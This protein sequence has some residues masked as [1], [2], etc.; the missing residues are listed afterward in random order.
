MSLKRVNAALSDTPFEQRPALLRSV[1]GMSTFA[2]LDE[3]LSRAD[4]H[5]ERI[6]M[7]NSASSE[8]GPSRRPLTSFDM[9]PSGGNGVAATVSGDLLRTLEMG[10]SGGILRSALT[11]GHDEEDTRTMN[12]KIAS[13]GIVNGI[14]TN[15]I[16]DK[17]RKRRESESIPYPLELQESL[18]GI[19]SDEFQLGAWWNSTCG[20]SLL[21]SGISPLPTSVQIDS[22]PNRLIGGDNRKRRRKNRNATSMEVFGGVEALQKNISTIARLRKTHAKFG[23]LTSHIENNEPI[24]AALAVVSSDESETEDSTQKGEKEGGKRL[25]K[26]HKEMDMPAESMHDA[27]RNPFAKLSSEGATEVLESKTQILLAHAG[28]EGAQRAAA[29]V[30]TDVASEYIMNLGRTIRMYM[31]Q[32]AHEMS[33]EEIVLHSLFENG[34]MDVRNLESYTVDD[35][36]RYGGKMSELL[37]KLQ[38]SYRDTLNTTNLTMED[39]A[40]FA[41]NA[42]GNNDQIMSGTFAQGMGDDFFGFKEMGLDKELGIDMSR[43]IVPSKLFNKGAATAAGHARTLGRVGM[44]ANLGAIGG[45]RGGAGGASNE[46]FLFEPPPPYVPLTESAISAQIGLLQPFYRELIRNRGQWQ[47]KSRRHRRDASGEGGEDGE[48]QEEEEDEEDEGEEE[49]D[50]SNHRRNSKSI[51]FLPEEEMERQRYKVPPNGKMPK[52]AMKVKG[53]EQGNNASN[54]ERNR[55][56]TTIAPAST[57]GVVSSTTSTKTKSST[58]KKK[59]KDASS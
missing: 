20:S 14:S 57:A 2:T 41:E 48:G 12:G 3:S 36:L 16:S 9:E 15:G 59:K 17:Q 25:R 52:R 23:A 28:F 18:E 47:Q 51:L 34:G 5:F 35:V 30:I 7:A 40:Y 50:E 11:M 54:S 58:S 19:V 24:P 31:D 6:Y 26:R 39:E 43:L 21:A 10:T 29:D 45:A 13:N 4:E 56:S 32:F 33:V 46:V 44:S 37:R 38:S 42:E 53:G 22:K 55:Q 27:S 49:E 8:A 1:D